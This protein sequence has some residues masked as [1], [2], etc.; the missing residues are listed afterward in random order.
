AVTRVRPPATANQA[1][2]IT[3]DH[4]RVEKYNAVGILI[5]AATGDYSP[6]VTQTSLQPSGVSIQATLT[7]DQIAGRNSCQNYNDPNAGGPTI[8]DGNCQASGG[9]NPIPPPLPLTTGPLF[10]QDGVRV[11]A[12]ASVQ[13]SDDTISSNFVHGDGA[14]VSSVFAPTP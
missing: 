1:R 13:M 12:G 14:P 2:T 8:I 5:D 7:S 4:T 11:T 6:S 3:I 9:S 10:G